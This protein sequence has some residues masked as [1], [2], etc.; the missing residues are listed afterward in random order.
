[1]STFSSPEPIN[2]TSYGQR[3]FAGVTKLRMSSVLDDPGGSNV[4]TRVFI[5]GRQGTDDGNMRLK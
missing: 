5:R 3:D 2:V 1:M 4:I